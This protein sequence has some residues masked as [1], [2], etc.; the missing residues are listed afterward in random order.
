MT[1]L[2]QQRIEILERQINQ[3]QRNQCMQEQYNQNDQRSR[4]PYAN[5]G[6]SWN[7]NL[8]PIKW[9][10]NRFH[11][12]RGNQTWSRGRSWNDPANNIVLTKQSQEN[13]AR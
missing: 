2:L 4:F 5:R 8:D 7:R 3:E 13:L 6:T 12:A 10:G 1:K 11:S 9:R